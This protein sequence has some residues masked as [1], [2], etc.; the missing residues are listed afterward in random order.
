M[1]KHFGNLHF[2]RGIVFFRLSAHEQR[3]FAGMINPGIS[4]TIRRIRENILRVPPPFIISYLVYDWGEKKYV[5]VNRK[6]PKDF[7]NDV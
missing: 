4:N 7:E 5:E 6:N 2:I 1:G 3:A